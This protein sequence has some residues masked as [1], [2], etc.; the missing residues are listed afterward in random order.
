MALAKM[1][2]SLKPESLIRHVKLFLPYFKARIRKF[3]QN[4]VVSTDVPRGSRYKP[5]QDERQRMK[6]DTHDVY[7]NIS[8]GGTLSAA[9]R[10]WSTYSFIHSIKR[11]RLSSKRAEKL[12]A[13]HSA[14]RLAHRKTPEYRKGPATRWDVD[15]EDSAQIDEGDA[16]DELQHGLVGVSLVTHESDSDPETNDDIPFDGPDDFMQE[17]DV[18]D[19]SMRLTP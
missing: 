9:E 5:S 16:P 1:Y 14:L 2:P 10:N 17:M 4:C 7:P 11:N 18:E 6:D 13:V 12:V 3:H 15:P 19:R 8:D